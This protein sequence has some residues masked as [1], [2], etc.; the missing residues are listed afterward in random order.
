MNRESELATRDGGLR[1]LHQFVP[2]AGTQ[3]TTGRNFDLGPGNR[4]NV[5]M[6]SPWLRHRLLTEQEVLEAVLQQHSLSTAN[7]FVQEV[8]WRTYFKGWLEH[9]PAVWEQYRSD[10]TRLL[11]A[12]ESDG[13][14]FDRYIAAV[15][16]KTGID[17]FD[18]W[19][20]ELVSTGYLHNHARMWFASIWVFTLNLP[21]Q[22]GADFFL[23]HLVDGDPASNTLGWRW[24]CGLHT[25]GKT[26]LASARNI[27]SYTNGRFNPTGQLATSAP[28]VT[29]PHTV[30]PE[31]IRAAQVMYGDEPFGLLVTEEDNHPESLLE[32]HAPSAIIA[33]QA[34]RARSPLPVGKPASEFARGALGDTV[35]RLMTRYGVNGAIYE[36]SDWA[37]LLVDW[38]TARHLSTIVTAYTPV[39]I[40]S[41]LL[42]RAAEKLD[43]Y[44]IKLLQLR[45][46]Y[47]SMAWPYTR[48]GY[49]KLKRNIPDILD[50]LREPEPLT[51]LKVAGDRP[52][53]L[54]S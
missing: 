42:A 49:F 33:I 22:L 36:S 27:V 20:A 24:V 37:E 19:A 11:D 35:D 9:R 34:T 28:S 6:L 50:K 2:R 7:K 15:Q 17:C 21:W 38:A 39:G 13:D 46:H 29:E 8:F 31:P 23:R 54:H 16:G 52:G 26:Y 41:E 25:R 43:R 5:S 14:L 45:R 47:D 44:G 4:D 32:N 12:L 10:V 48:Q 18:A 51:A 53:R 30:S 1:R 3:Y 40:A